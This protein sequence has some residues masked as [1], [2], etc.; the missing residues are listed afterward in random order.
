MNIVNT[1]KDSLDK[2]TKSEYKV[3]V[4]CLG[5]LKDFAFDTLDIIA[6]KIDTS[7]TS[8][9]R[10]CRKMGFSGYKSFQDEVRSGFKYEPDLPDKFKRT[11]KNNN[12]NKLIVQ[13]VEKG[14]SCVEKTF[15]ELPEERFYHCINVLESS[16]RVFCFGMKESFAL[17]HYAYTRFL[18]VRDNVF[19]LSAGYNGEIESIL[20]L[21][22]N[23]V[24]IFFLFHRYTKQSLK[25][26]E[27]LKKQG[28]CVILIT[29]PPYDSVKDNTDILLP[30]CVDAEGIKNSSLAPV[31]LID[32][33]CNVVAV[34]CGEKTL[35]HMKKSENLF[36]EILF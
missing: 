8:V 4:Y 33:L 1:V 32:C 25:I 27:L 18:T 13:T 34:A 15:H 23:D 28:V 30:C 21:T 2:M 19:M 9:I 7:T 22:K 31:C 12:G 35:E 29:S 14:I 6:E 10:F 3:A 11:L 16:K 24:C 20:S 17:A 5:N 36:K 26:L